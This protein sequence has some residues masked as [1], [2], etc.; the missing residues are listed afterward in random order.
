MIITLFAQKASSQPE[1]FDST[2]KRY[3]LCLLTVCKRFPYITV[4]HECVHYSFSE[5]HYNYRGILIII[6]HATNNGMNHSTLSK[7]RLNI[8]YFESVLH[9]YYTDDALQAFHA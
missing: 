9:K 8:R 5:V 7:F 1:H 4:I 2:K 3:D 6:C